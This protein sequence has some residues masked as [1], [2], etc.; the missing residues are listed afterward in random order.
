M[1]RP[2]VMFTLII[3]KIFHP[4]VPLERI[5]I[6]CIFFASPKVSHF[7]CSRSLS[8]DGVVCNA[9][10]RHVITMYWY[11]GLFMSE[12]FWKTLDKVSLKIIPSWQFRNNAPNSASAADATTNRS[13]A[14]NV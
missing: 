7:H 4:G 11:F 9:D 1:M 13:I 14:H 5:H 6:L 3:G 8:F 12:V 2:R 10:S